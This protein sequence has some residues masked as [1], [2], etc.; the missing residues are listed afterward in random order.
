MND[1]RKK[2]HHSPIKPLEAP[3][4]DS[5]RLK[6]GTDPIYIGCNKSKPKNLPCADPVTSG[7]SSTVN[8]PLETEI[9][10][11]KKIIYL[12]SI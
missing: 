10:S 5:M 3:A 6:S 2:T 4:L 11:S 8:I 12:T 7:W 1:N 9:E